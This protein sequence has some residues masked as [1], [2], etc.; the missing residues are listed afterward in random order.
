MTCD[1]HGK[2]GYK[3]PEDIHF[4]LSLYSLQVLSFCQT[5]CWTPSSHYMVWILLQFVSIAVKYCKMC[6]EVNQNLIYTFLSVLVF[7]H[8]WQCDTTECFDTDSLCSRIVGCLCRCV[9]FPCS[10]E[11]FGQNQSFWTG[12]SKS[13][14]IPQWTSSSLTI[15]WSSTTTQIATQSVCL[16]HVASQRWQLFKNES[17]LIG[18]D[19]IFQSIQSLFHGTLDP[20][21]YRFQWQTSLGYLSSPISR[22]ANDALDNCAECF[23]LDTNLLF[24]KS[25]RLCII[26]RILA[27]ST[28]WLDGGSLCCCC[29]K[30]QTMTIVEK[31]NE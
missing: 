11:L 10:F 6:L 13:L 20:Q 28:K 22:I 23:H 9:T 29:R 21:L 1:T 14:T 30:S 16:R 8:P 3:F 5:H 15:Q 31:P 27:Q 26:A 25:R 7:S 12:S 2:W 4:P 19:P 17:I 18:S 24:A